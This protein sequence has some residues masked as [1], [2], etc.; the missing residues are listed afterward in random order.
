MTR[1]ISYSMVL[2]G[3][4]FT[5]FFASAYGDSV[6][7]VTSRGNVFVLEQPPGDTT[8]TIDNVTSMINGFGINARIIHKD[9]TG[10]I[11]HGAGVAG[12]EA[13]LK[14]YSM[15]GPRTDFVIPVLH[16]DEFTDI[17]IPEFYQTYHVQ[18]KTAKKTSA[19]QPNILGYT[20][21]R[22]IRGDADV[23]IHNGI[24]IQGQGRTI[25]RLS[26]YGS[27]SLV[28]TGML[29][30]GTTVR[31]VQSP[32]NLM[33]LSYDVIRGFMIHFCRC[34][35]TPDSLNILAG[36]VD[37]SRKSSIFTYKQDASASVYHGRCCRGR[38]VQTGSFSQ[39]VQPFLV[40]SAHDS[41]YHQ[42]KGDAYDPVTMNIRDILR[43]T[44][45]VYKIYHNIVTDF[46][47][48]IYDTLPVK[49]TH[50]FSGTFENLITFPQDTNYLVIDS[51][52]GRSTIKASAGMTR[53]FI[54]IGGLEPH[55]GYRL[56]R[57]G[58]TLAVGRTTIDGT[59]VLSSYDEHGFSDIGGRLHVYDRSLSYAGD[60]SDRTGQITPVF[61]HLNH[62]ILGADL[63]DNQV[64]NVY[65]YVK[66]PISI[67]DIRVSG[68]NLDERIWL[69]YLDG[70]Y[71]AGESIYVPIIP[72]YGTIGIMIN[73]IPVRL[74]IADV[75]GGSTLKI[76]DPV[77]STVNR[78]N[79]DGLT[80]SIEATAGTVTFMIAG[81]DGNAKAHLQAGV[82][83]ETEI[84]NTRKFLQLPPPPPPP[85]PRDPMTVW[86]EVYVNG[87]IRPI[88]GNEK[89]QIFFSDTPQ[90]DHAAGRSSTTT[91]HVSRFSYEPVQ[92]FD[93]ISVPVRQADFVEFYFYNK[94]YAQGSIPPIPPGY[95]EYGQ[96]STAFA[97]AVIDYA[98]INTGM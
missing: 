62:R 79:P 80:R 6:Q 75:L 3:V 50:T 16:D 39:T 69:R 45:R 55:T 32:Y 40:I 70:E 88:Q 60:R 95:Q 52:G 41:G 33:N 11:I 18:D 21:T 63:Q 38:Y 84:S 96:K 92:I 46:N 93:T 59:V 47:H 82:H 31:L 20:D 5:V 58:H 8:H 24:V 89:T 90:T 72:T 25:V 64:Y 48:K 30:E 67:N 85:R 91:F 1:I 14:P 97:T 78:I 17:V 51:A 35:P 19:S 53:D 56:L 28:M 34:N 77:S 7:I 22:Q 15:I 66:I 12:T 73:D 36:S 83:G 37:D 23:F 44:A 29:S 94:I 76:A 43:H 13:S 42:I 57:D 81:I 68:I 2:L 74:D 87:Q 10:S 65:A 54:D 98:S 49:V 9:H 4:M 26:D 71:D 86:V 61:D 27:Q